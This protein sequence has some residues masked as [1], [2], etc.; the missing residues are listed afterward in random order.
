MII[1]HIYELEM[2][3]YGLSES[4]FVLCL[5]TTP[6]VVGWSTRGSEGLCDYLVSRAINSRCYT[7]QEDTKGAHIGTKVTF[8]CVLFVFSSCR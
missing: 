2:I 4:N 7:D 1:P 3:N 6:A 5:P 8:M